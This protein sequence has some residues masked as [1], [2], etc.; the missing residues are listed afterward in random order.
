MGCAP[1]PNCRSGG[2]R[3]KGRD[4]EGEEGL[5][6]EVVVGAEGGDL[7]GEG[8][9]SGF[10]AEGAEGVVLGVGWGC[11]RAEVAGEGWSMSW[12]MGFLLA[13][14][15]VS[16][17]TREA[18]SMRAARLKLVLVAGKMRPRVARICEDIWTAWA[19][20]PV[21]W[22]RAATKRL[23]KLWPSS[24]PWSKRYWKSRERRCSSSERATMQLRTSPGGSILKSSRGR[25]E[26]PPAAGTGAAA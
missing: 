11:G 23:P 1:A 8:A 14:M 13:V 16:P 6:D 2:R 10:H 12:T 21:M 18:S 15:V 22:E 24:S 3:R 25:P 9:G 17:S 26:E 5:G 7:A 19:K 20:S 4:G